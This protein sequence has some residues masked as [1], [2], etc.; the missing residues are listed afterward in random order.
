M[1]AAVAAIFAGCTAVPP[2]EAAQAPAENATPVAAPKHEWPRI[3]EF[4]ATPDDIKP[5]EKVMLR[6][7]VAAATDVTIEPGVGKVP[8]RGTAEVLPQKTTRYTL[9]A[10]GERGMAT[11]WAEVQVVTLVRLMPD[12]TITG[13]SYNSGLLYYTIKNTGGVD[14]GQS[15]TYLYDLSKMHRDTSWVESLKAGEEKTLPFTN[16][17]YRG[18]EIT[19]CADGGNEVAEANE[20]NNCYVPTF[21]QSFTYDF[22]QYASR[23]LWR[24]SAGRVDLAFVQSS[25]NGSAQRLASVVA[26]DGKT[27][28]NVLQVVPPAE[29]YGWIEGVFGEWQETWRMGGVM[30]PLE[31]PNNMKLHALVGFVSSAEGSND[32]TFKFGLMDVSGTTEWLSQAKA[33]YDGRLDSMD[34]DLAG[35]AGRKVLMVLRVEVGASPAKGC[36]IWTEMKLTQQAKF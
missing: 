10:A 16:F 4:S 26:E 6:W 24:S 13:V 29:S 32:V 21:G 20:D 5:G 27:Y 30:Q 23:A 36:A 7:E 35:Y 9:T 34:V 12:L 28:S 11:G 22:S 18:N 31:M 15:N 25:S 2:P 19:I 8:L 3:T 1:L 33:A 14:A 17:D